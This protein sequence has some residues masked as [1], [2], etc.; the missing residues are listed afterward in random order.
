MSTKS[1]LEAEIRR[2][3]ED[4]AH[5]ASWLSRAALDVLRTM[6]E[7]TPSDD[8]DQL[9]GSL[10]EAAKRLIA[11]RPSMAPITNVVARFL[12]ETEGLR[13]TPLPR[14]RRLAAEKA[15]AL[16]EASM[17]ALT[18][19]AENAAGLI[20]G[21][22]TVLTYSYS[23]TVLETLIRSPEVRA[24]VSESRPLLEGRRLA[25]ELASR[26]GRPTLII[27]AAMARFAP[28]ADVALVGAD[29]VLADGSVVNKVGTCLA[30]L[31]AAD[32]GIPFYV[33]CET[34]KFDVRSYLGRR[35][36]LEEGDAAEVAEGLPGVEV[37]N[38]YFEV[39]PARLV[40]AVVT[41]RG[42]MDMEAIRSQMEEMSRCTRPLL[43]AEN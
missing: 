12:Y 36:V 42:V 4:K 41:E 38:P 29:S 20:R 18:L 40:T 24:I 8:A 14:F 7:S 15:T 16:S 25:A 26:G 34:S 28:R 31:A 35:P 5:G 6:A 19:T 17:R 30:A 2:I 27:D 21:K 10:R 32:A 22:E 1:D 37:R 43:K 23:S 9:L 13:G 11:A 3:R 33:A 39:V